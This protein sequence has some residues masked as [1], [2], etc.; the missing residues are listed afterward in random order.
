MN[1]IRTYKKDDEEIQ[2]FVDED[3]P[4]PRDWD[5]LGKM[6]CFHKRYNLGDKVDLDSNSFNG[7]EE[8]KQY[9]IKEKKAIVILPIFMYDHSGITINTT[10][11]SCPWDSGQIGFI[12]TTVEDI[13]NE[14]KIKRITKKIENEV[15]KRLKGEIETYDKYLTGDIYCFF[16]VKKLKCK[17]CNHTTEEVIDSCG[18]IFDIEKV[19]EYTNFEGFIEVK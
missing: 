7:W 18:G 6:V 8:L 9:L 5:N 12:Y 14:Y 3:P 4:N 16:K 17:S 19:K 15:V 2:I 10:G 13:K 1:L 11:F